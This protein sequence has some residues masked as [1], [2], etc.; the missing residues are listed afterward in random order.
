MLVALEG[1]DGSGKSSAALRV[2]RR[3]RALGHHVVL[4]Q[5]PTKTWLGRAVRRAIR[6][7]ADPWALPRIKLKAMELASAVSTRG[8]GASRRMF[9]AL[10]EPFALRALE[11]ERLIARAT[12]TPAIDFK[13]LCRE[14]VGRL[15]PHVPWTETFLSL[16][17]GCYETAGDV[18]LDAATRDLLEFFAREPLPLAT[19][20]R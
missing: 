2:A 3:L 10:G 15:E 19:G 20:I 18:R 11:D 9:V 4:T 7:R 8:P 12:L 17:R 14:A 1:I 16:R 13:G 6:S 5:E